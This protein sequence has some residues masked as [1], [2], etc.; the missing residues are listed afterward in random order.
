MTIDF[1]TLDYKNENILSSYALQ[2]TPI[3]FI[4]QLSTDQFT[5]IMWYFGDGTF[6]R[7]LS[8]NKYYEFPGEYTVS[9]IVYDCDLNANTS[10]ITK[11]LSIQDFIP[12]TFTVEFENEDWYNNIEIK[13]GRIGGPIT[14]KSYCP[15]NKSPGNI[16]YDVENN[17]DSEYYFT[18]NTKYSHLR[19]THSAFEKKFNEYT[20]NYQFVEI[21]EIIPQYQP[22]YARKD[23]ITGLVSTSDSASSFIV[24]LSAENNVY[25]K[26]DS[27]GTSVINLFYDKNKFTIDGDSYINNLKI[28]LSANIVENDDINRLSITSNGLDGEYYSINSF[29]M[30]KTK[31]SN[32]LFPFTIKVKDLSGFSVKNFPILQL[33]S[34]NISM[35]SA[36]NTIPSEY[37]T[38]TPLSSFHGAVLGGILFNTQ[39]ET[40]FV[41]ISAS[42]SIVSDQ[43]STFMLSGNSNTFNIYPQ[44]FLSL[45]KRNENFDMTEMFKSLRFQEF[46][47]DKNIL[48]DDFMGSIFGNEDSSHDTIGKKIH[49][50][51]SNFLENHK[52]I[53]R[54]EVNA[55][56]SEMSMINSDKIIYDTTSVSSPEKIK[57]YI[58]LASVSKNNLFGTTN[59]FRENFDI[60]GYSSKEFYGINLG[61]EI[62]TDSYVISA[63]KPIVAL[64]MFS[65]RYTLLNTKQPTEYIE[66]DTYQL[67]AYDVNWGWPLILPSDFSYSDFPK[68]Y[69]FFEYVD[70]YDNTNTNNTLI[71]NNGLEN[72]V[73]ASLLTED[74]E[75]LYDGGE[76]S[77]KD[78]YKE[79]ISKQFIFEN[80]ISDTLYQSLSLVHNS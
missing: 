75:P 25:Y 7:E 70:E 79:K 47:L 55:L 77:N 6:S 66:S 50:K 62:N 48:F 53:D 43:L 2:E 13:N 49:E 51:I 31:F 39:G 14:I 36:G 80:I 46:L 22:I 30:A 57:R 37:Y 64:E 10:T 78:F 27:I 72:L 68:Y 56:L 73:T 41:K 76:E 17:T 32:I 5:Q 33:S 24:G 19:K 67:S 26:D 12:H 52:D 11:S 1:Y 21:D 74:E 20:Q 4:P 71:Y 34:F 65:N 15:V 16:F 42:T 45:E 69:R 63:N 29:D 59:K 40:K 60:K 9:L 61:D 18:N 35:L 23:D 3:S 44:N 8:T 54:S 28:S 58:N 38:I